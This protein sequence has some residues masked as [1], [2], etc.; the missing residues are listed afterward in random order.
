LGPGHRFEVGG[1]QGAQA[2]AGTR[3]LDVA[4]GEKEFLD[5]ALQQCLAVKRGSPGQ[6]FIEHHPQTVDV[7]S[8]ID[9]ELPHFGLLGAHVGRSA[10]ERLEP[11]KERRVGQAA[12]GGLGDAEI[13]DF[14]HRHAVVQRHEDIRRFDVAVNDALLMRVL[15]RTADLGKE[16]EPS[17]QRESP[18]G[19][20]LGDAHAPDQ[21]HDEVRAAG[22][23]GT[24]VEHLGDVR[25]V[26]QRQRLP[27]RLEPGDDLS[28]VHAQLDDFQCQAPAHRFKL[29]RRIDDPAATLAEFLQQ[30]VAANTV[31]RF[32]RPGWA[33]ALTAGRLLRRAGGQRRRC[34]P[35]ISTLCQEPGG[36][37]ERPQQVLHTSQQTRVPSARLLEELL[38]LLVGGQFDGILEDLLLASWVASDI[39]RHRFTS[40]GTR[41]FSPLPVGQQL[42]GTLRRIRTRSRAV[43]WSRHVT[44]AG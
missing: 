43:G 31:A 29:L 40:P 30:H 25:V 7:A 6:Q 42:A 24:R 18:L 36:P 39:H 4:Q 17:P 26:H 3:R 32:L 22:V 16:I 28:G 9:V 14:R 8:G 41:T 19:T 11:R 37:I 21:L 34:P 23:R 12:L 5:A 44:R 33:L 13:D 10:D 35:G 38:P 2:G 1:S 20:E 27:L 15:D